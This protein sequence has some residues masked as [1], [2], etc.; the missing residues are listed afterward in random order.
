MFPVI[1]WILS[2]MCEEDIWLCSTISK[3]STLRPTVLGLS[4]QVRDQDGTKSPATEFHTC[5]L[6]PLSSAVKL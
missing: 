5:A 1:L 4:D 2:K 3:E 6:L